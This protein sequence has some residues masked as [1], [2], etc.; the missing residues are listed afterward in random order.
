MQF[1]GRTFPLYEPGNTNKEIAN[2]V[3]WHSI[4]SIVTRL[5]V[6]KPSSLG[7]IPSRGIP[8]K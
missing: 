1:H 8:Y 6:V 2:N 5:Q 7:F 3:S 4:I